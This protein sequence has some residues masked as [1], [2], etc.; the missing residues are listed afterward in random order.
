MGL[1]SNSSIINSEITTDLANRLSELDRETSNHRVIVSNACDDVPDTDKEVLFHIFP[2]NFLLIQVFFCSQDILLESLKH[3]ISALKENLG[4]VCTP[5]EINS[6]KEISTE[7]CSYTKLPSKSCPICPV[8]ILCVHPHPP[9]LLVHWKPTLSL[10]VSGY[11][12]RHHTHINTFTRCP[13]PHFLPH[14]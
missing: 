12:V 7:K 1:T 11:E 3:E 14:R 2:N 9:D 10:P 4:I 6:N 5:M 8:E 13:T